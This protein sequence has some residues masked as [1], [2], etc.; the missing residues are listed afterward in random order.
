MGNS[1]WTPDGMVST[2]EKQV[3]ILNSNQV[4]MLSWL[5]EWAHE[6]GINIFCKS[7]EKPIAGQNNDSPDRKYVSVSCQCREW[8]FVG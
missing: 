7:C 1:L 5:H 2:R 3:K 4:K 8:R 6:E